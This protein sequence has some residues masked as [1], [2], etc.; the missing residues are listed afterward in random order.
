M[1]TAHTLGGYDVSLASNQMGTNDAN[2]APC[3]ISGTVAR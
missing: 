3:C 1:C 2:S